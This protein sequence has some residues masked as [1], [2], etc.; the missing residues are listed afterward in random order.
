M[1][2]TTDSFSVRPFTRNCHIIW[3]EGDH[4]L[5]EVSPGNSYFS[6]RRITEL[7]RW[8]APR[9]T[10]VDIVYADLHVAA[11]FASLGHAPEQAARRAAKEL[12]AV[13][14][15]IVGGVAA[16]GPPG[17]R[18]GVRALSEF[19]DDRVYALLHRRVQ[20]FLATDDEF[21]KSCDLMVQQFLAPKL[22][23]GESI[24]PEQR[25]A[26]LDY[27]AAEL[28]FF[29]DTPG[30]LGVPSSVSCYNALMPLTELLFSK[31]GGLRV[32]RNQAYAVVRPEAPEA[33]ERSARTMTPN[34]EQL[35]FPLSRRG[36]VL[37]AECS[38]LREKQPVA[39]VR[40]LTGDSAWLVSSYALAKQILDDERFSLKDTAAPGVPRQYALTIPPEVVNNMGNISSTGLRGA[41]MKAL[42]PRADGLQEWLRAK[43]DELVDGLLAEGPRSTSGR[44]SQTRSRLP[45]T[46]R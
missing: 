1:T 17:R 32:A 19:S 33:P 36:D 22:A 4:V 18:I 8:A 28:P 40:T 34:P 45:C 14:R 26:C 39:R 12:K 46:A 7:T 11:V 43:A 29:L 31:G 6:A 42:S 30:I 10:A 23:A 37:P 21:R 3:D 20:H 38:W 9:S 15:R 2:I 13:R 35:D 25:S 16:A 5:I 44:G 27:I 41:V 24:S